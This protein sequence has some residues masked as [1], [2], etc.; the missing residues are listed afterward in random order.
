MEQETV[1][2][3]NHQPIEDDLILPIKC[4]S[5]TPQPEYAQD[6]SSMG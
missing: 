6:K 3:Y 5:H 4:I 1:I 2:E